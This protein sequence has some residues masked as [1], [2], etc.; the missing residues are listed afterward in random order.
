M[1]KPKSDKPKKKYSN[2]LFSA[3]NWITKKSYNDVTD[4]VWPNPYMINR[5]LTMVS[6]SYAQVVNATS[7]RWSNQ[8]PISKEAADLAK[9]FRTILPKSGGFYQYIKKGEG[10]E[11]EIDDLELTANNM[12]MSQRELKYYHSTLAEIKN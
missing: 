10:K 7:N 9:F 1:A 2:D 8:T 11:T 3:L 4:I 6:G 12:E 5:W